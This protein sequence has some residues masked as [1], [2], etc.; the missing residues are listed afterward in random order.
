MTCVWVKMG[1]AKT[2]RK[3]GLAIVML[4]V[5][6]QRDRNRANPMEIPAFACHLAESSRCF[7]ILVSRAAS[8]SHSLKTT[9]TLHLA[10]NCSHPAGTSFAVSQY[11]RD[12]RGWLPEPCNL[13]SPHTETLSKRRAGPAFPIST[14]HGGTASSASRRRLP[15]HFQVSFRRAG[16]KRLL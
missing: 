9:F 12:I 7:W 14:S 13:S 3:S 10:L 16:Q 6:L 8:L 1:E 11:P 5:S 15:I 2:H 4:G